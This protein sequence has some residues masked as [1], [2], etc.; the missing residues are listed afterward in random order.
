MWT[1]FLVDKDQGE[2]FF[3][4]SGSENFYNHLGNKFDGFSET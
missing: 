4:I 2:H 1:S 3:I